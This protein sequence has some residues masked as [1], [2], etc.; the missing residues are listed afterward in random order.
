MS[1]YEVRGIEDGKD[2]LR[3]G[4]QEKNSGHNESARA[5]FEQARSIF[6][7]CKGEHREAE[8]LFNE[9]TKE[10]ESLG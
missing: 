9:V 7:M 8:R 6:L 10:L 5:N 1:A 4:K 3:K 2:Y